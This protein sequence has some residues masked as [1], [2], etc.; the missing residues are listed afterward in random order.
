ME[1]KKRT[2]ICHELKCWPEWY[3]LITRRMMEFQIRKNDKG[4][5]AGDTANLKE[6]DPLK[7]RFTGHSCLIK[8][9]LIIDDLPGMKPGYV[10]FAHKLVGGRPMEPVKDTTL[11][12][13]GE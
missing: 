9:V 6:Y 13:V 8:I 4:F 10:A 5:Q 11:P 12:G 2:S 1:K 7:K 3:N